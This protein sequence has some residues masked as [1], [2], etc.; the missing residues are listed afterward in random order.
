MHELMSVQT[1][2]SGPINQKSNNAIRNQV[3]EEGNIGLVVFPVKNQRPPPA[4]INERPGLVHQNHFNMVF[5]RVLIKVFPNF[6]PGRNHRGRNGPRM[7]PEFP[8]KG[9]AN[10]THRGIQSKNRE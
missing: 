9:I 7:A 5:D 4:I 8:R 10:E 3:V 6:F 2:M 1:P